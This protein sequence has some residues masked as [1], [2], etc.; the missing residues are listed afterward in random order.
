MKQL[1]EKEEFTKIHCFRKEDSTELYAMSDLYI[2]PSL[3]E[4]VPKGIVHALE[5]SIPV[6][7][8]ATKGHVDLIENEVNG[9]LYTLT[10]S[11]ILLQALCIVEQSSFTTKIDFKK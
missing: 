4:G 8:S 7:A 2:S 11:E 1:V 5:C 6:I 3:I 9:L 10:I